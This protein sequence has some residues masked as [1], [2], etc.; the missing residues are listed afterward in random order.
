MSIPSDIPI[1]DARLPRPEPFTTTSFGKT[2]D[3]F[4]STPLG[5]PSRWT[6]SAPPPAATPTPST[7]RPTAPVRSWPTST[8]WHWNRIRSLGWRASRFIGHSPSAGRVLVVIAYRD[9]HGE[10]HGVNARPGSRAWPMPSIY[11]HSRSCA[12]GSLNGL[13]R[14]APNP[15]HYCAARRGSQLQMEAQRFVDRGH[16]ARR[17]PANCRAHLLN[18]YRPHLLSLGLGVLLQ[19]YLVCGQHLQREDPLACSLLTSTAGRACLTRYRARVQVD[20]KD[21]TAQHR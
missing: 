5:P 3:S 10:L 1:W 7:S 21:L 15:Q 14:R 9:L 8:W 20:E 11:L 4:V 6:T 19:S 18:S 2:L 12:P 16:E 17:K 13:T